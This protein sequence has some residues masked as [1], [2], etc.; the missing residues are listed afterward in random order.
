MSA[1]FFMVN[2][3]LDAVDANPGD[4]ACATAAGDCTLRAAVMEANALVGPDAISLPAGTYTLSIEL[5]P[6]LPNTD[7][8]GDLNIVDDVEIDGAGSGDSMI[9]GGIFTGVI[10]EHVF[11]IKAGV[12]VL[13]D[14]TIQNGGWLLSPGGGIS[15]I[16]GMLTLNGVVV[17]GNVGSTG[18]GIDN[19][20]TLTVHGGAFIHNG[21][22]GSQSADGAI[23]N[24]GTMT[25]DGV[26]FSDNHSGFG[27]G[28]IGNFNIATL[29][30]V[31][32]EGNETIGD[33]AGIYNGSKMTLTNSTIRGNRGGSGTGIFNASTGTLTASNTTISGNLGG[34]GAGIENRG[35]ATL[36]NMTIAGNTS[37]SPVGGGG[38]YNDTGPSTQTLAVMNTI[39]AGNGGGDCGGP[40]PLVS[41]GHNLS[42]DDTCGLTGPGDLTNTDPL[43]GPL[44]DN[45]GPT[46]T[47]ALLSA[48]PAIDAG[49]N[50]GCPAS[51]QRGAPRPWDG[52]G[53]GSAVCDIGAFE[54]APLPSPTP[55]ATPTASPTP[56]PI[57][58]A[59]PSPTA[60]PGE[61][62]TPA[63]TPH[64]NRPAQLPATGGEPGSA[65]GWPA[66]AFA[67][68]AAAALAAN[69]ALP[70]VLAF[71]SMRHGRRM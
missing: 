7:A 44:A 65:F 5:V 31:I 37:A 25:L 45:G 51:D 19:F 60:N 35:S 55:T 8:R 49:D 38:I 47:H 59:T 3:T 64:T 10:I 69:A 17:R 22:P 1:A 67:L 40:T 28:A 26:T 58:T 21:A 53:D 24:G 54:V 6:G 50:D 48:G 68:F 52:D 46:E 23:F 42:G 29:N 34:V 15:N 43:L 61:T 62:S 9:D 30:N 20:G 39:V 18:A 71:T 11:A 2:S 12:V 56:T 36:I 32:V 63:P 41:E 66:P 4:G 57:S 70:F 33:G 27:A 13:S 16:G 14:L